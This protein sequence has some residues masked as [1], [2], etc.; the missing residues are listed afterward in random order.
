VI[1]LNNKVHDAFESIKAEEELK[2]N[3]YA[4]L[5]TKI[6]QKRR[7]PVRR[8]ALA[9]VMLFAMTS[10]FS[11]NVYYSKAFYL[12]IDVNPSIELT[13]NRFDRIIATAAYN[14]DGEQILS[15]IS[16]KN[17]TYKNALKILISEME[18]QGYI[19]DSNLFSATLQADNESIEKELL[20]E[21]KSFINT[22]LEAKSSSI[23]QDI[24][25]VDEETKTVAHEHHVSPAK[26]LAIEELQTLMPET[27]FEHNL[28]HSISE[29]ND[30]IDECKQGHHSENT[31]ES[32]KPEN[33]LIQEDENA[34]E[35]HE[36]GEEHSH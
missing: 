32:Q 28:E 24:F 4:F 11:Y 20:D 1:F 33:S 12:D 27:T 21:I 15:N 29:I 10:L 2:Q 14:E 19:E 30:L 7:F 13:L 3:T 35:S 25:E 23:K 9:T 22:T 5:Q 31:A 26:Y 6:K 34:E 17:K 36:H 18:E 8:V 16:I